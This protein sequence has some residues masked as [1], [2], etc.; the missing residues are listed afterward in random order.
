M[1]DRLDYLEDQLAHLEDDKPKGESKRSLNVNRKES[2][3]SKERL[4]S[5][6][7]KQFDITKQ[8]IH[9]A[10]TLGIGKKSSQMMKDPVRDDL[11][12]FS[13]SSPK[14]HPRDMND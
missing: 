1:A 6:A 4:D 14:H 7:S 2:S 11:S 9:R 13:V 12:A 8:S 10:G 5:M 3:P